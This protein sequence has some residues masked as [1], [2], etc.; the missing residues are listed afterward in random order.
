VELGVSAW[1]RAGIVCRYREKVERHAKD[2]QK[3]L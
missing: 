1:I 3:A 2:V